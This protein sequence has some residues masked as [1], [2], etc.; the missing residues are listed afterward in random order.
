MTGHWDALLAAL[1]VGAVSVIAIV[2]ILIIN[3]RTVRAQRETH[4]ARQAAQRQRYREQLDALMP[5]RRIS[6]EEAAEQAERITRHEFRTVLQEAAGDLTMH[7]PT[8]FRLAEYPVWT[9]GG[10]D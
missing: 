5:S 2:V 1:A 9:V 8:P 4:L 6:V 7:G 10:R 3:G